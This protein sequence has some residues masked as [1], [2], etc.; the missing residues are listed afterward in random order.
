VEFSSSYHCEFFFQRGWNFF[1][2]V[3]NTDDVT[4]DNIIIQMTSPV[5]TKLESCL[6]ACLEDFLL[7]R[8]RIQKPEVTYDLGRFSVTNCARLPNN[9][10]LNEL[11]FLIPCKNYF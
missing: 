11:N 10:Q 8:V 1:R 4:C 6:S 7:H 5:I 9:F 3:R 2:N